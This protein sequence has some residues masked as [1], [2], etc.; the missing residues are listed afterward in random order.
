MRA[1]VLLLI[2]ATASAVVD[3]DSNS[4]STSPTTML[5]KAPDCARACEIPDQIATVH[6]TQKLCRG[7]PKQEHRRYSKVL[8]IGLPSFTAATVFLRC[9]ARK[10]VA[11]RL[12]WDDGTASIALGFLIVASGLGLA[13]SSL[14]YG[15][16]Y[17]DIDPNNGKAILKI[18]YAQQMLYILVQAFAK[19]S[20]AFFYSPI[21]YAGAAC[22]ILEDLFLI[23]LPIPELLKLQ[24]SSKKRIAL[25]F[26]FA[27]GSFACIASMVRLQYLVSF[28]DSFDSTYEN[29]MTVIWS[30]VELSSTPSKTEL[31]E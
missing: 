7:Y 12:W 17:W 29:V 2:A 31:H 16:H 9:V 5:L 13:S 25:V 27:L 28:A 20:I 21:V 3:T 19:A 30:A 11:K 1:G 26:M 10:Q 8:S 22:S 23:V 18:F 14:G 4:N 15:S 24:L 6:I